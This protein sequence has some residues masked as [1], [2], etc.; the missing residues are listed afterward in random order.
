M[1]LLVAGATGQLGAGLLET[2]AE[3]GCTVVPLLRVPA[4]GRRAGRLQA[5]DPAVVG[6][7]VHGDVRS[8]RWGM[9]DAAVRR[10]AAEADAVVSLAGE[11]D[12]AGRAA[13]LHTTHV[14][15]AE[16]G[17]RLA[18]ELAAL[19]GRRVPYLYAGSAYAAGGAVGEIAEVPYQRRA[20]RT[21]Y[22]Q[23]KWLAERRLAELAADDA[24]LLV[25]RLCAL[26]GSSATGRTLRRNSL[27]M[28][29]DR[30]DDLPGGVLPAMPAARVDALPRDVAARA[31]LRAVRRLAGAPDAGP[32][33]CHLGLGE[34]AP[35]VRGLL[36][37][38]FTADPERFR[39]PPRVVSV[40]ARQ[41]VWTSQNAHR[42]LPLAPAARNALIGLRYVGLDRVFARP[43]LA[44]LL[45][46]DLPAADLGLLAGLLFG[47]PRRGLDTPVAGGSMARF[48]G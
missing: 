48:P 14:L 27:Y 13:D 46:G 37:A 6:E 8:P 43:R 34:A 23:A 42:F 39:R 41:L 25:V 5:P 19:S 28:L 29:A 4:R 33:I 7:P 31:L 35:S 2:A 26:V 3:A 20:D 12:W 11:T 40:T 9:D 17:Y 1:R 16:H 32:L 30:W 21:V 47:A 10:L 45:G 44:A 18:R 22:E 15:G 24:P 36:D 38:A